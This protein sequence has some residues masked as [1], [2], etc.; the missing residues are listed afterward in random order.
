L[1]AF[2]YGEAEARRSERVVKRD[3]CVEPSRAS[4]DVAGN[5]H[6]LRSAIG[7]FRREAAIDRHEADIADALAFV[8]KLSRRLD[9]FGVRRRRERRGAAHS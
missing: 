2:L 1:N 8:N 4:L 6:A 9:P 3:N 5:R 7:K